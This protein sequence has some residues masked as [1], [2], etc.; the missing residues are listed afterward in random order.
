MK[1]GEVAL[2]YHSPPN[3]LIPCLELVVQPQVE[4]WFAVVD[5]LEPP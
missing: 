3:Q 5:A 1:A 2:R 4:S